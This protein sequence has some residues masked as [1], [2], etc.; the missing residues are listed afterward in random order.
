MLKLSKRV[1]MIIILV[2]FV[3]VIALS[4]FVANLVDKN[5]Y[6]I[7]EIVAKTEPPKTI[8]V[9]DKWLINDM[10]VSKAIYD[11]YTLKRGD[12]SDE[13]FAVASVLAILSNSPMCEDIYQST[14]EVK[15]NDSLWAVKF[16]CKDYEILVQC[17]DEHYSPFIYTCTRM[18]TDDEMNFFYDLGHVWEVQNEDGTYTVYYR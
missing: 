3:I 7:S 13:E 15:K 10:E 18:F 6:D 16:I 17:D 2:I 14:Y 5:G 11:L 9:E 4:V 8:E 12:M 1:K